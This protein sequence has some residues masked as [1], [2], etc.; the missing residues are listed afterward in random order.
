[1]KF[2]IAIFFEFLSNFI[3][4]RR[5]KGWKEKRKGVERGGEEVMC[6]LYSYM[7]K[8]YLIFINKIKNTLFR[9]KKI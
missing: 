4:N 9:E 6:L 8:K 7:T 2:K 5:K 1:M 3:R